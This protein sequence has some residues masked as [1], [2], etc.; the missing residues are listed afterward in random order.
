MARLCPSLP[1]RA[2]LNVGAYAELDLLQ[3][4]ECDAQT[5]DAVQIKPDLGADWDL[6]AQATP[7]FDVDQRVNW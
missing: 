3:W 1:L 7:D 6:S 2:A 5:D 4:A